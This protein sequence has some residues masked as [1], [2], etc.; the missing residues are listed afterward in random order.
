MSTAIEENG[1]AVYSIDPR[2]KKLSY[3]STNTLHSCPR[4]YQLYKG[5]CQKEAEENATLA[6][7]HAIGAGLQLAMMGASKPDLIFE[8][9]LAWDADLLVE[10]EK[11]KKSIWYA[12]QAVEK[13]INAVEYSFLSQYEVATFKNSDGK[14]VPAS[15]LS[16]KIV[17]P[18]GF[19]YVG[20][21]DLVLRHKVTGE[22]M[23][24]E[25]KTTGIKNLDDAM[26][27]NSGQAIGYSIILD[28]VAASY[29]ELNQQAITD[30][31]VLYMVY[32]SGDQELVAM[33]FNKSY[34][35]K[36]MWIQQL[37]FD[38]ELITMFTR[39]NIFP[40]YGDACYNF[41]RRCEY[42]GVCTL[43]TANLIPALDK[44]EVQK[45]L[46]AEEEK[47]YTIVLELNSIITSLLETEI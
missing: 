13:L 46:V 39:H 21:V 41:F 3:S 4:K 9:F 42:F 20:Y 27:K 15:E 19:T 36:A 12:I 28:A 5:G 26:Y 22:F 11:K 47:D 18:N 10:E 43:N 30:Y 35:Q 25:I 45:A 37:L 44:P 14:I 8:M 17:L 16:F 24:L 7:G 2:Y 34:K 1:I 32:K 23:V 31:K 29:E 6:F 40:L 33:P 38:I